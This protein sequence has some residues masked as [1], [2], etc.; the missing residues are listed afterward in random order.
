MLAAIYARYSSENQRESSIEDQQRNCT[1]YAKRQDW[2]ITHRYEDK[3]LSGSTDARPGY[4]QMLKDAEAH[5]FDV[6]LVD[7]FSRLSRDQVE[8]EK[9]RRQFV[10]WGVRLIGVSDGIDTNATGH[11]MLSSFK[12]IMNEVYL[13]DLRD[14]TCRGMIG[15]AKKGYHCGGRCYGYQLVPERDPHRKD[16]YGEPERI[17]TRLAIEPEQARWVRWVYE[18]YAEGWSP[19]KIVTELNRQRVPP[20]GLAFRRRSDRTPTWCTSALHGDFNRG[21]GLLNNPLYRGLHV[22]NRRAYVR[23]PNRQKIVVRFRPEDEWIKTPAPHLR[24][25]GDALWERVKARQQAVREQ[26]ANIRAM[27]HANARTGRQPKYLFSG[28]L[29]CAEC[30]GHFVIIDHLQASHGGRYG[31]GGR[32]KRGRSVCSNQLRVSRK[33][34]E[35]VLLEAIQRDLFTEEGL[36][37]FKQEVARLLAERRQASTPELAQA[38]ARL[39]QVEQE[40]ANIMA[41]IKA[42]VVTPTTKTALEQAEAERAGLQA[43]LHAQRKRLDKVA[44]FLPDV[45]ER[46]KALVTDLATVTQHQVDKARG[47]L[48]ELVGTQIAL[49]PTANGTERYLIA[50]LSGDYAGLIRLVLGQNK[51]G[52]GQG[53]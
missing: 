15:Q 38:K 24:I 47:I 12:G 41:A 39:A 52:G 8:T 7:D 27:L 19:L 51:C 16:A 48:R 22:W 6:L 13:D 2:V 9:A 46:F 49:H 28:L 14:K 36:Q 20:P 10:Y 21:T 5:A 17:G 32:L 33:L 42:G 53:I 23:D 50:E 37:V 26:S 3:A 34:V 45:V 1:Q 31:C 25:V 18:R 35:T 11:K 4:K 30:R 40:I 29:V 43:T 44:T